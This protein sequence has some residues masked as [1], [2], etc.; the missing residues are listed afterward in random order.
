[1]LITLMQNNIDSISYSWF[2][3]EYLM[4]DVSQSLKHEDEIPPHLKCP[5]HKSALV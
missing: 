4:S 3:Y 1:M 5:H 2:T